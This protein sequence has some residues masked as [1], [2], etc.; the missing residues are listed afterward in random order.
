M[1][2][3]QWWSEQH[4]MQQSGEHN[5]TQIV[6]GQMLQ[7]TFDHNKSIIGDDF[8]LVWHGHSPHVRRDYLNELSYGPNWY[9]LLCRPVL[10]PPEGIFIKGNA[11]MSLNFYSIGG[12]LTN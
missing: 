2:W 10:E 7:A 11:L 12:H 6:H 5:L 4:Q 9:Y 1:Q 8:G 3:K